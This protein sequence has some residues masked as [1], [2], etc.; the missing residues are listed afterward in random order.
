MT[1][2][3]VDLWQYCVCCIVYTIWCNLMHPLYGALPGPYVPVWVTR[4]APVSHRYTRSIPRCRN[5]LYSMSFIPLS[6]SLW[7]NLTDSVFDGV[8]LDGFKSR[9]NVFFIRRSCSIPTIASTIFP[10]LFFQSIYKLLLL[11]WGFR[12][13]RVYC[14]VYITLSQPCTADLFKQ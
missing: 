11:G 13:D 2:L 6:V 12:T 3:I 9:A 10:F 1:L 14:T 8:G 7:N 4:G 5:S